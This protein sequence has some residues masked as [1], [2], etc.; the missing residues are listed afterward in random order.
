MS[1]QSEIS[2]VYGGSFFHLALLQQERAK[3]VPRWLHPSPRLVVG[4]VV[5]KL[6][7]PSQMREGG[8]EVAF[9]IRD[10]APHHFS[11]NRQNVDAGVVEEI[12][13]VRHARARRLEQRRFRVGCLHISG[14]RMSDGLCVEDHCC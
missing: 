7:G 5:V 6:D 12:A 8:I 14:G 11:G 13:G 2:A 3:G 4:Q 1:I 10:L 9:P